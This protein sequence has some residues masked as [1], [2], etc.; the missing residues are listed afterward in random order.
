MIKGSKLGSTLYFRDLLQSSKGRNFIFY[1]TY[2]KL[3]IVYLKLLIL[4][5]SQTI[6]GDSKIDSYL[7]I[8]GDCQ[9][10]TYNCQD[11]QCLIF[12]RCFESEFHGYQSKFI[13]EY[14]FQEISFF[15]I[16]KHNL[17]KEF[18]YLTYLDPQNSREDLKNLGGQTLSA[19]QRPN[20]DA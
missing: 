13:V 18:S 17:L 2:N 14:V 6:F 19:E 9:F 3:G 20:T 15:A 16:G 8:Q 11:F 12:S 1:L 4:T 10:F 5:C 7:H